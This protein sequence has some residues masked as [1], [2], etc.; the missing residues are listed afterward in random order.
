MD[1]TVGELRALTPSWELALR[2]DR[3]ASGT[4][5]LY[6]GGLDR[7]LSWCEAAGAAPL[8]RSAL[9]TWIADQLDSGLKAATVISRQR[10]VMRFAVWLVDEGEL[11]ADPFAGIKAPKRDDRLIDPLDDDELRAMLDA[12]KVPR[13][14]AAD[15]VFRGRRDE[16]LLRLM[17]ETGLR[18]NEVLS[19]TVDDID[20][21]AGTALVRRGK[22]GK[23]RLVPFGPTTAAALDRYRR[24]RLKHRLAGT[25]AFWLGTRNR[26]LGYQALWWTLGDRARMAGV[27]GFH[28]HRMRHT[29]AHRWLAAGGSERGLM[30]VAGWS[31]PAMLGRYGAA[32]ATERAVAESRGLHLGE[33]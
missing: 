30:T 28:P 3:K 12:C 10:G 13:G 26:N 29:A 24:A 4:V 2:A 7:Y 19:L 18:A 1:T 11:D 8:Q 5:K 22:G 15:D 31:S 17:L 33:L 32:R 6:V 27:Q 21:A 23:P 16:A 25:P 14:A 9:R 20:L